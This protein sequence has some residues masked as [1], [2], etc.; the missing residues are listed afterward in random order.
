MQGVA[1]ATGAAPPWLY[2]YL[3]GAPATIAGVQC[4]RHTRLV[5]AQLLMRRRGIKHCMQEDVQ[6]LDVDEL[7]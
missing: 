7:G 4:A 3:G 6:Q 2:P 1:P 5:A